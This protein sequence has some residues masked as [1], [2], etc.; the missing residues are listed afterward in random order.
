M[1]EPNKPNQD[2]EQQA[3]DARTVQARRNARLVFT[4]PDQF[5]SDLLMEQ[6]E[7]A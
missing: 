1:T 5:F 3:E 7:Q 6:L 2:E 4:D